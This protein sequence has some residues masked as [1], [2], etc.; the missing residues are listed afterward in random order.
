MKK[1]L[2]CTTM[3]Y[4]ICSQSILMSYAWIT[5]PKFE[6][7]FFSFGA[8]S[9]FFISVIAGWSDNPVFAWL[10]LPCLI[11]Q[12]ILFFL[13]IRS[14][15]RQRYGWYTILVWVDFLLTLGLMLTDQTHFRAAIWINAVYGV[16]LI[17]AWFFSRRTKTEN[18]KNRS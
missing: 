4:L 5:Y 16:I 6:W 12:I 14:I 10:I 1:Y 15:T 18:T 8:H 17:I 3:L 2:N 13:G 11:F 9:D 7:L